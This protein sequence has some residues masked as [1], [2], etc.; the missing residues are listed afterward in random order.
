MLITF[1]G[2]VNSVT[3]SCHMIT[4][5]T[6]KI[7]LDCGMYQGGKTL[8]AQNTAD[9]E[10]V[11]SD[12][13][14]VILSHAHVD[15]CGRLPLLV[16][17][18]FKGPIYC[19]DATADLLHIMLPDCAYIQE[20]ET[21]WAN[22]KLL[23]KGEEPDLEPMYDQNDVNETLKLVKP[24]LYDQ[25][26]DINESIKI[27][28]NDAGHI[29]G[30]AITELF[31]TEG[32][33]TV[34]VVFSGD[35]GCTDRPILRDPVKIK[36]ADYVIMESTYGD[37][38]HE[39]NEKSLSEL[40]EIIER[41]IKRGG[42]V[43]IPSFAVGR[44]QEL[45]YELNEFYN[46][47]EHYHDFL[48][49]VHVYIDSPMAIS[50]TMVFRR[51]AQSFDE[52]TRKKILEGDNPL[53]FPNLPF[54]KNSAESML[55]N[56]DPSPKI[57]IAASG[58]CDA[59]RICHHLKHNLWE[60]RNSIVIVG[61]QAAGTLGR[62]LVD[63]ERE[64]SVLGEKVAVKA[65]IYN[66][67][68]F[69]GHADMDGLLDWVSGFKTSPTNIFL[70]HGEDDAKDNLAGLIKNKFGFNCTPIHGIT[71]VDTDEDGSGMTMEEVEEDLVD[72]EKVCAVRD[73]ILGI[74][75]SIEE[76]LYSANLAVGEK[77]TSQ[78]LADI[79]N[80]VAEL[81]KGTINLG[82]AVT[83]QGRVNVNHSGFS[84]EAIEKM[85]AEAAATG[86]DEFD[87]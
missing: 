59:G 25:Q 56:T 62:M 58:M 82:M 16:K 27:V 1:Y 6:H 81:E 49:D 39:S 69:S 64:V 80:I 72:Y 36:K 61:Y 31:V 14:C 37:R 17:R 55:L 68:G 45:I 47:N 15:H 85:A 13:E 34:K 18:G 28:F 51:N 76:L 2:A 63:G 74:H 73:K 41:T 11:P 48:K 71:S 7:L 46:N 53:V 8:E 84:D 12:V 24:V 57:I 20:K 9:F 38:L 67:E 32:E 30:S 40:L 87:K 66:L 78:R 42:D 19:T 77:I 33:K 4:T 86:E 23:R 50:T 54:T 52:E 65:E 3:G 43:I 35:I 22:R 29:L 10:F 26:I 70:V 60:K 21:E 79:A 5:G 75:E 44:T 83:E